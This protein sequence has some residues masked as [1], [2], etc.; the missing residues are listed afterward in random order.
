MIALEMTAAVDD[1]LR[2]SIRGDKERKRG[3]MK[4]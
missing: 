4:C 2:L 1:G 3:G